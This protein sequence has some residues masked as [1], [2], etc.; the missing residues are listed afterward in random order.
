MTTAAPQSPALARRMRSLLKSSAARSLQTSRLAGGNRYQ[1]AHES[2]LAYAQ[3]NDDLRE[4]DFRR[5][6]HQWAESW[7]AAGW[8][9][10]VGRE[11]GT[12]LYLLDTYPSTLTRDPWRLAQLASDIG[13]IEASVRSVG[14]DHVL[15]DLRRASAA[16][17]AV[18]SCSGPGDRHWPGAQPS[19][20]PAAGSARLYFA[21]V[22]DASSRACRG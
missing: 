10:P 7:R 15:A 16:N 22:V 5:R 3:V 17:P 12:P 21:P 18:Q 14:V 20:A 19:G 6:I 2:L 11:E 8:P 1:F 13:W 9:A 4:P